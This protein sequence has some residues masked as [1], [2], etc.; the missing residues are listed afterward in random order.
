MMNKKLTQSLLIGGFSVAML[1]AGP[2]FAAC[3]NGPYIS[4]NLGATWLQT[5]RFDLQNVQPVSVG[6]NLR[7]PSDTGWSGGLA[8]GSQNG[9]YRLEAAVDYLSNHVK[10]ST[11]NIAGMSSLG[12]QS[13]GRVSATTLLVN[14][15]YDFMPDAMWTPYAGVG[16]GV[17]NINA[18]VSLFE[19]ISGT[20]ARMHDNDNEFAYQG[21]LGASWKLNNRVKA[22][23]DYRYLSTSKATFNASDN[24]GDTGQLKSR[25]TSNRVTA[26]VTYYFE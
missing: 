16:L 19:P 11:I 15:Y 5:Q 4:G 1:T 13:S 18:N 25:Y 8:V 20:A 3:M 23:V 9:P 12:L 26:G 14:G 21:I 24:Q 2:S 17:A 6:G 10:D 22:N 7:L